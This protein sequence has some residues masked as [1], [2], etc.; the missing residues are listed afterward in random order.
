MSAAVQASCDNPLLDH[1]VRQLASEQDINLCES[2]DDQVILVVNTAS[3]CGNTPQ[4]EGLEKLHQTY[5]KRGVAVLGFPSND[6]FGQEPGTEAEIQKFCRTIYGV[7]FPMFEKIN[8]K[9]AG[10]H[11]LYQGL[12]KA[13]GS[14][15]QW[16]FHKYLIDRQGN[17]QSFSP[18]TQPDDAR[19]IAALE[20]ALTDD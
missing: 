17:V 11:P 20:A 16:N 10:A 15:P 5:A 6:F 1:D 12:T 8:V 3:R 7:E 9:G 18:R 14:E 4:Y 13:S 2:F 19:L